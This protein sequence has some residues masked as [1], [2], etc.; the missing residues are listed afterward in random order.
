MSEERNVS[1]G[2]LMLAFLAGAAAGAVVALL[3][4]PK[5]GRE[6]RESVADWARRSGVGDALSRA[7]REARDVFDG[8]HEA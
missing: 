5:S 3:T 6:T 4:A 2:S 7:A 1:A 8:S